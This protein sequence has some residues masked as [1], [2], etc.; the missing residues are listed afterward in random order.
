MA[1][2]A[3]FSD[4]QE[5]RG[6]AQRAMTLP[7]GLASPLWMAFGA[8]ASDVEPAPTRPIFTNSFH[9]EGPPR[10]Q[11]AAPTLCA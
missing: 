1:W 4:F 10:S 8:A 9:T 5:A 6:R 7:I 3:D 2:I 11:P